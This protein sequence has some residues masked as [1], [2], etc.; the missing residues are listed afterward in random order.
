MRGRGVP[1]GK[2]V[3]EMDIFT[4]ITHDEWVATY[5]PVRDAEGNIR[6]FETYGEDYEQVCAATPSCVWT[7]CD[8]SGFDYIS[9]GRHWVDRFEYYI[10][11]V[12]VTAGSAVEIDLTP[13]CVVSEKHEYDERDECVSCGRYNEGDE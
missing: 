6:A 3:N 7:R 13:A 4:N 12:A 11:E 9:S 1:D 2:G 10:T 5:K 8:S